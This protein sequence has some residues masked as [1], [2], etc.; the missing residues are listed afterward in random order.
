[1]SL[2]FDPQLPI[3]QEARNNASLEIQDSEGNYGLF[4][5]RFFSYY[6][7]KWTIQKSVKKTI[8]ENRQQKIKDVNPRSEW[9]ETYFANKT[10]GDQKAIE[11]F[12]RRRYQL[13]QQQNGESQAFKLTGVFVTGMGN[14]HPVEN[15]MTWHPTLGVPYL[16]G[17]S[18]KGVVRNI[19]ESYLDAKEEQEKEDKQR[20][21]FTLFGSTTKD[22]QSPEFHSSTGGLIFFDAFPLQPVKLR[23]EVMTPHMGKWYAEGK[24]ITDVAGTPSAVPADWHDPIPVTYL[25]VDQPASFMFS[26][27]SCSHSGLGRGTVSKAMELL[28]LALADHGVGAKTSIGHGFMQPDTS[29]SLLS[30]L[31]QE[32]NDKLE[33]EK[34]KK[35]EETLKN[36][37]AS[38]LFIRFK[39]EYEAHDLENENNADNFRQVRV[40]ADGTRTEDD[41]IEYWL[42][43]LERNFDESVYAELERLTRKYLPK[44]FD[45]PKKTRQKNL[46]KRFDDLKAVSKSQS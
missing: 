39:S 40:L 4:F 38:E 2:D 26:I 43:Q 7:S 36:S 21:L 32:E 28:E 10:V 16:Q 46:K 37:G 5:D 8:R 42:E 24:N 45:S 23:Q 27:A 14:A 3:Y 44:V 22:A 17:S 6:Q 41:L 13:A 20:L 33:R 15:G 34:V 29:E 30:E 31:R 18:V 12:A 1:M 11:R 9:L 25:V 35:R 19:V